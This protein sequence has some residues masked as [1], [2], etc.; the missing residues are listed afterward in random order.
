V[1]RGAKQVQNNKPYMEAAKRKEGDN[2]LSSIAT[3]KNHFLSK[4]S[5]STISSD[6]QLMESETE[7]DLTSL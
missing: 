3:E 5:R 7:T 2:C 4:C 6:N 1:H